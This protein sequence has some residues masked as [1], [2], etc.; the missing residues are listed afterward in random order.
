MELGLK[1]FQKW[2]TLKT[3][4]NSNSFKSG[5][6]IF[7]Q[8]PKV[9]FFVPEYGHFCHF[10]MDFKPILEY[11]LGGS[12]DHL[13]YAS[14]ERSPTPYVLGGPGWYIYTRV[15]QKY[16]FST[17]KISATQYVPLKGIYKPDPKEF[18][19]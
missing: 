14:K 16:T 18:F 6:R 7:V 4:G 8:A 19:L 9:P 10:W 1:P 2:K 15:F 12:Q 17:K 3:K 13:T 11:F 5:L